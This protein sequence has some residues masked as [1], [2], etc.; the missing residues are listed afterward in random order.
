ML[1]TSCVILAKFLVNGNNS[2]KV[3]IDLFIWET[4]FDAF[5]NLE[6]PFASLIGAANLPI[7][8]NAPKVCSPN[9]PALAHVGLLYKVFPAS[10]TSG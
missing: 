8:G 10:Y 4:T 7:K 6:T 1:V 5:S 3:S 9:I 2:G